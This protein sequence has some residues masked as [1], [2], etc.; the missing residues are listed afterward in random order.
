MGEQFDPNSYDDKFLADL[1][2]FIA[3][4]EFQNLFEQFFTSYALEFTDD[5]EHPLRYTEIFKMFQQMF[6][7]Q[8][9]MFCHSKNITH[10]EVMKRVTDASEHDSRASQYLEILVSSVEYETFVRLM[11]L[12][13][14]PFLSQI[15]PPLT[16]NL[17]FPNM[18]DATGG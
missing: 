7:E 17:I 16:A 14:M 5:D 18:I 2:S 8:L 10:D 6:D 11:R 1:V 4:D 13:R 9:E 15:F 12:V 3:A